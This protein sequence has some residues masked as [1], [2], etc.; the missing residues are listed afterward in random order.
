M[1]NSYLFKL[2][3]LFY[4][5]LFNKDNSFP[6][7]IMRICSRTP[8]KNF[9]YTLF[10]ILKKKNPQLSTNSISHFENDISHSKILKELKEDGISDKILLKKEI[11]N[12][13]LNGIEGFEFQINRTKEKILLKDKQNYKN[14]Y[15]LR[16]FNPHKLISEIYEIALNHELI[17][18]VTK[19]LGCNP[20]IASSQIWWTYP[21]YNEKGEL[22]NPPGNEFGFH[23][24][25]DDF[26]FLKLFFYLN[27][28]DK[29]NGPHVYIKNNGKKSFKEYLNRRIND[30]YAL[31][32][33]NRRVKTILGGLGSGFIEDT[34]F[35][36]KGSNPINSNGRGVLQIIYGVHHWE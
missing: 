6:K 35:Y 23:Y 16:L 36:H 20:I 28:V 27:D 7:R 32:N 10:N 9:I 34:S 13:I 11:V 22:S 30:D 5:E 18:S 14:I 1:K 17:N 25:V 8:L 21:F 19:Y 33:Y 31:N 3:Q 26:K 2:L 12:K 24:D 29:N 4:G 15:L